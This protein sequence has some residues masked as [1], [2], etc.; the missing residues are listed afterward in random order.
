V[1]LDVTKVSN[2][3]LKEDVEDVAVGSVVV[4]PGSGLAVILP[5]VE[6][7]KPVPFPQAWVNKKLSPC[8]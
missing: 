7:L 1:T 5:L 4:L 8:P 6:V 3:T 2:V